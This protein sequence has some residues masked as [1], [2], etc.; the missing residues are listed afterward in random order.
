MLSYIEEFSPVHALTGAAKL[1][2]FLLWSVLA[3]VSYQTPILL[4]LAAAG[5]ALSFFAFTGII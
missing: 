5:M 4:F 2:V 3:M 1:I